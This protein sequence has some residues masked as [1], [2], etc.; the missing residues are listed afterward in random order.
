MLITLASIMA[1]LAIGAQAPDPL[2]AAPSNAPPA[3]STSDASGAATI[4][5][6]VTVAAAAEPAEPVVER[7]ICRTDSVTGS[8]FPRRTCRTI[9]QSNADHDESREM[10]RRLQGSRMPDQ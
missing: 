10:L 1:T 5:P 7:M 8:N 3:V 4:L 2:Q 9:R 6:T